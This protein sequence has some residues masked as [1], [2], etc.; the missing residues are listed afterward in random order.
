MDA[1]AS[2]PKRPSGRDEWRWQEY[3]RSRS[4]ALR[5]VLVPNPSILRL[6]SHLGAGD[7][8]SFTASFSK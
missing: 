8:N 5:L 7:R 6:R 4:L 2:S 3:S 1:R